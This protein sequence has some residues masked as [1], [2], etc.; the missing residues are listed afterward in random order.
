[1]QKKVFSY[2]EIAT[3]E[4]GLKFRP[5]INHSHPGIGTNGD[6]LDWI[7]Y[8][9]IDGVLSSMQFLH[10]AVDQR[11]GIEFTQNN[12]NILSQ[13]MDSLFQEKEEINILEIG[14]GRSGINSSTEFIVNKKRIN[15]KYIGI[16][17]AN[18]QLQHYND[19]TKKQFVLCTDSS[20]T[21]SILSFSQSKEISNFDIIMIDG[22]H[23][24]NQVLKEWKLVEYLNIGG[25]VIMHDS[26]YHPG[27]YCV[28]EA[29]DKMYFD[30]SKYLTDVK[31]DPGICSAKRIK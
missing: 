17:I 5:S 9:F 29:I 4:W 26:N 1:M 20:N 6:D 19:S 11:G 15:D 3:S 16:D 12:K 28:Y 30:K 13:I 2:E 22:W 25:Y 21:E 10:T 27:P 8:G 14:V 24:I 23:S 31:D 18:H 7:E